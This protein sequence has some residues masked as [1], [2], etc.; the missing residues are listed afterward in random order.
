MIDDL[1]FWRLDSVAKAK[2]LAEDIDR[3]VIRARAAGLFISAYI[4]EIAAGEARKHSGTSA[5]ASHAM[6]PLGAI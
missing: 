4:L 1:E 6:R 3:L 5:S 2:T